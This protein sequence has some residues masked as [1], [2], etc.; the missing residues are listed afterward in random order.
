MKIGFIITE[1]SGVSFY[2]VYQPAQVLRAKG[3]EV[4]YLWYGHDQFIRPEWEWK[5]EDPSVS[6]FYKRD[7][8]MLCEWSDVVVWMVVHTPSSLEFFKEMRLKYPNKPFLLE[9]D[10][11]VFDVPIYNVGST[12]YYPGSPLSAILLEQIEFSN[13][14]I[15]ST[16]YLKEKMKKYHKQIEVV[17]NTIDLSSWSSPP[18]GQGDYIN[19]GWVGGATHNE[20]LEIVKDAVFRIIEK[21]NNIRFTIV[22]G[23]PE[24]FKHQPGCHW[25][26][27]NDPRYTKSRICDR[28][29]GIDGI[30][31]THEFRPI[32]KYPEFVNGFKFDI[33]IAPL[34]DN[35]FNRAKSNLR[36][37]EYSAQG[38]PTIASPVENF[39]KSIVDGQTG[40]FASTTEEWENHI[41]RL[42]NE[43]E[44]RE[45]IG[46]RARAEVGSK[47]NP[48]RQAET[49]LR[50]LGEAQ[51]RIKQEAG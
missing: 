34:L 35:A 27:T 46:M 19:V 18:R 50:V 4:V 48:E 49:Y 3:H 31:W 30:K 40:L 20:D 25:T 29:G 12:A 43:P 44:L 7:L 28:C 24:F 42:A 14:L 22:H 17:Q 9:M 23:C 32:D 36:W 21:N 10:D 38:I 5:I 1:V 15:V 16:D 37:M 39:K 11:I 2:R 8:D 41:T 33:G 6:G 45:N 13:G 26:N 47:W 51:C